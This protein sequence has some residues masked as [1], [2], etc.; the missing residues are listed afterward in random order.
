M[1]GAATVWVQIASVLRLEEDKEGASFNEPYSELTGELMYL[2]NTFRSE[3][4]FV[5]GR[6][7]RFREDSKPAHW[8]AIKH[9]KSYL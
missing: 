4:S 8:R 1:M 3:I 9:K 6:L 5:V 7:A 2:S